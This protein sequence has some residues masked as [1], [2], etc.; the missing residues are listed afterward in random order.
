LLSDAGPTGLG[1]LDYMLRQNNYTT[2]ELELAP[3][4]STLGLSRCD[5]AIIAAPRDRVSAAD[6]EQLVAFA[7]QG[8]ALFVSVGPSLD[9][10][11]RALDSGLEPLFE[12]FGVRLKPGLIFERDPDAVLP[13][14]LGGEAF[15][16]SPR[17]HSITQGL[18]QGGEARARVLVQ[19]ARGLELRDVGPKSEDRVPE[20]VPKVAPLLA[21]SERAFGVLDAGRLA[22]GGVDLDKIEHD[23]EGPYNVGMAIELGSPIEGKRPGRMVLLGSASPVLGATFQ[24]PS[25]AA[26][27]RFVESAISWLVSR[28]ALVSLPDKPGRKVELRFTEESLGQVV[29]YVLVY[30]PATAL[31]LGALVLYRRRSVHAARPRPSRPPAAGAPPSAASSTAGPFAEEPSHATASDPEDAS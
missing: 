17:P 31:A 3:G 28:P 27:R 30:M 7:R 29:R 19:L 26:T 16:A 10:D 18:M 9:E 4:S 12:A 6:A 5:L 20:A 15:L 21:S 8:K 11:N 13:V 1:A 23:S 14:G 22:E 2:R 24:D 25:L